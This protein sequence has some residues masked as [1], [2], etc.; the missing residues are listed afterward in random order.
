[1]HTGDLLGHLIKDHTDHRDGGPLRNAFVD[2]TFPIEIG[3]PLEQRHHDHRAVL[4]GSQSR[5][6]NRVRDSDKRTFRKLSIHRGLWHDWSVGKVRPDCERR[7]EWAQA[8]DARAA[9][10]MVRPSSSERIGLMSPP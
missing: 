7:Q 4:A 9:G 8:L 6:L 5:L 3:H 10:Y 1:M 2:R